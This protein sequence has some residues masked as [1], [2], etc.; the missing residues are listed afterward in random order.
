MSMPFLSQRLFR[1]L[2]ILLL[3]PFSAF[4]IVVT[5]P[6]GRLQATIETKD[7]GDIPGAL[8]YR[9]AWRGRTI[10][11]DSRLG[12][13]LKDA[14]PLDR[15]FNIFRTR[16]SSQD[17]VWR[18]VVG[19]RA[20][21]R[22]HYAQ[23]E[24]ELAD[25]K[26]R[27]LR[28][29]C[30][31]Y[32]E[33][34]AFCYSIPEQ[35]TLKEM[36]VASEVTQFSFAAN[37]TAWPVYSAQGVYAPAGIDQ[38]KPNCERPLTVKIAED[39]YAAIGEAR[40]IDFARMR[41]RPCKERPHTLEAMLGSEA[42]VRMPYTTPW[43]FIMVGATPGQL[44]ENNHLVL[45]LNDPCAIKDISWIKP[46]KVIREVTL[47]TAGGKACVDFCVAQGLQ[48]IEYD[49]GWYGN[50]YDDASDA[51]KVD[52]DPKRTGGRKDLDLHEVIRYAKEKNIGVILYVNR[53]ALE[54]QLD[55]ILPLFEKWGVSGV[56]YGFVNVGS[57]QWTDW[58]HRAIRKAAEHRLMVDVHDEYRTT[59]NE[60]TY[61]NLMT[62]EGVGG[63]ETMP[64]PEQN[65]ALPF[66]RFLCGP[67]DCTICWYSTRIKTTRAH[68]LAT[69]VVFYSP[70]QFVY[71]YDRPEMHRGEKE[72]EFFRHVPTAWDETKVIHGEI[73]QFAS[74]ARRSGDA[75]FIGTINAGQ[76]RP[77]E[78]PLTFLE[79]GKRYTAHV[80]SDKHPEGGTPTA[81]ECTTIPCDRTTVLKADLANNGGQTIRIV[82]ATRPATRPS[83]WGAK[84][85]LVGDAAQPRI[86]LIGDSILGGYHAKAADL[87]KAKVSLD[88]WITP[89]HIGYKAI[90][91]E[92]KEIFEQNTY[93]LILFN[94]IGLHA[95]N[96]GRIPENQ[97]EPLM[98]AH[99]ANLQK[100]APKAK[101]IFASTTPMTTKTAPIGF[102]PEFN[103]LIIERNRIAMKVMEENRIPV[104]DYYQVLA[105]KLDLAAGDRF[106]WKRPAYDLLAQEAA[107][108]I[109]K[110]LQLPEPAGKPAAER[111]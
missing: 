79:A 55:E 75:W 110:V 44:I 71:W 26:G 94:D 34:F 51:T 84:H 91:R 11:A 59:G 41:L 50:E 73:G 23:V 35:E 90:P 2:L 40:L 68:Q 111:R 46:G 19:E 28:L 74:I 7:L 17:Q 16:A 98:R 39:C 38:I 20:S 87:L 106:H 56:K 30:R 37:H 43:R 72:T 81:V 12:L 97:Y 31:A 13:V 64:T 70:W 14:E 80:Y 69:A 101:L 78:I 62:V 53:R 52:P 108:R 4:G 92:M 45:N 58:L 15:N 24:I 100:L 85:I 60:R 3:L 42:V 99:V 66:T 103:G 65:A 33:G 18:P 32:D 9:L 95:W 102:D 63:N 25:G 77:L 5:S 1:A 88:V 29:I 49:A 89:M 6:D 76:R 67:A 83:N 107:T 47:S 82:P 22:D 10:L 93:D 21:V 8:V 86:L 105:S 27:Q 109:A 61:P 96:P 57:Q 36:T 104:T 48:Y 54:R